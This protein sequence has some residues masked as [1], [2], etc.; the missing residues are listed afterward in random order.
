MPLPL[1]LLLLLVAGSVLVP[2]AQARPLDGES[3]RGKESEEDVEFNGRALTQ[4]A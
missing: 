3:V 2:Q 4:S 1:L